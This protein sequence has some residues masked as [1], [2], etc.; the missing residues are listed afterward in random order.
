MVLPAICDVVTWA[1]ELLAVTIPLVEMDGTV[2]LPFSS[3]GFCLV[4]I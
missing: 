4:Y 3:G 2:T 1:T